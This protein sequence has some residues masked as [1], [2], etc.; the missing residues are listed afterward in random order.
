MSDVR[1]V[2]N[3]GHDKSYTDNSGFTNF[4]R[5]NPTKVNTDEYGDRNRSTYCEKP[6]GVSRELA[7][8]AAMPAIVMMSKNKVASNVPMPATLEISDLAISAMD[9][10]L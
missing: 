10:P 3:S 8:T 5:A 4:A 9:L 7:T 2:Y 1:T 6:M